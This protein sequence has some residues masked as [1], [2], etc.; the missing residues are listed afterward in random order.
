[1]A[2]DNYRQHGAR[3]G[4]EFRR[5]LLGATLPWARRHRLLHY[6]SAAVA[7]SAAWRAAIAR[8]MRENTKQEWESEGVHLG[9]RYEHSPI[10]IPDGTPEPEDR[11]TQYVPT[12]RP[13]H[14]APHMNL[15]GHSTLDWFGSGFVLLCFTDAYDSKAVATLTSAAADRTIPLTTK[16]ITDPT[17]KALY[18]Y[19]YVLVRPDGHVAWRSDTLDLAPAELLDTVTGR[20]EASSSRPPAHT[21]TTNSADATGSP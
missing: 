8:A 17:A 6:R 15:N 21:N 7:A 9:Y 18:E 16:V 20:I 19:R 13:G 10:V 4:E 14:R 11:L 2:A 1:M 3:R 5:R 12:A